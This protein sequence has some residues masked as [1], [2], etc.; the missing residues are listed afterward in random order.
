MVEIDT[1]VEVEGEVEVEVGAEALV[2]LHKLVDSDVDT[3]ARMGCIAVV[4]NRVG[5]IAVEVRTLV[6]VELAGV[7][8][9]CRRL[10]PVQIK[11]EKR[12]GI[13]FKC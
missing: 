10:W 2:V 3:I 12:I 6:E 9:E 5:C 1:L 13:I 11:E 8:R 4:D 7:E